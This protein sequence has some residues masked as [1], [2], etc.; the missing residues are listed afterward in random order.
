MNGR[1]TLEHSFTP[2]LRSRRRDGKVVITMKAA[3]TMKAVVTLK[4]VV[5]VESRCHCGRPLSPLK[6]H[7]YVEGPAS[8]TRHAVGANVAGFP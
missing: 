7:Y 8:H 2:L 3:V 1:A 5:V 6:A 4:S